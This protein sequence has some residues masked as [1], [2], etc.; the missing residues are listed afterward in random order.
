MLLFYRLSYK[1]T[2]QLEIFNLN[3]EVLH[4]KIIRFI[5][6]SE[7]DFS[8]TFFRGTTIFTLLSFL[9]DKFYNFLKL[10]QQ[11]DQYTNWWFTY[12]HIYWGTDFIGRNL[13][14]KRVDT[15]C[16]FGLVVVGEGLPGFAGVRAEWTSSS[17]GKCSLRKVQ[18]L[19]IAP[20]FASVI[21]AG[22]N[23]A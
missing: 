2:F 18:V 4:L 11:L 20:R 16:M 6:E 13:H 10:W 15:G 19:I 7:I 1:R 12:I 14:V 23:S 5:N 21:T 17:V 3:R 8:F 9:N 22:L